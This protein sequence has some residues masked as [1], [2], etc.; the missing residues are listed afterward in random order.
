MVIYLLLNNLKRSL[1]A[2]FDHFF[3]FDVL[4]DLV[5]EAKNLGSTIVTHGFPETFSEGNDLV[6]PGFQMIIALTCNHEF[7]CLSVLSLV[8]S[9]RVPIFFHIFS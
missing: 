2:H 6:L 9:I 4:V 1:L 7:S 5:G 3:N 8:D